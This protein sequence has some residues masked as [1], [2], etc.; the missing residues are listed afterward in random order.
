MRLLALVLN[1]AAE[2]GDDDN[3]KEELSIRMQD[4]IR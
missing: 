4:V 1:R 2:D 3:P